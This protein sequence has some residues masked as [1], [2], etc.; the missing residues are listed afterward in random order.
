LVSIR[1]DVQL[2]A[3]SRRQAG[4]ARRVQHLGEGREGVRLFFRQ[5]DA[6]RRLPCVASSAQNSTAIPVKPH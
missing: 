3:P 6:A 1:P 4:V 5:A 2:P